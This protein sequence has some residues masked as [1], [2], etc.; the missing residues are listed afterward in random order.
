MNAPMEDLKSHLEN[1]SS[2]RRPAY[3]FAKSEH[4]ID[5][6]YSVNM[7]I[8]WSKEKGIPTV[9]KNKQQVCICFSWQMCE[10]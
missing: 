5:D 10:H 9:V 8:S 4:S 1:N 3:V 6:T 7:R 2:W